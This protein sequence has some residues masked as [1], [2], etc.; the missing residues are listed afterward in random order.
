MSDHDHEPEPIPGLPEELP[1]GERILWQGAP[2]GGALAR[3]VF[4]VGIVTGYFAILMGWTAL[5]A[6]YDGRSLPVAAGEIVNLAV[7]AALALGLLAGLGYAYARSTMYTITNRRVAIRS[8]VALPKTVNV[9]FAQVKDA[10]VKLYNDGTGD[11]QT[12]L[13]GPERIN[14]LLLWPHVRPFKV[15]NAQPMLRSI[16]QP[17]EVARL[18]A[19][20]LTDFQAPAARAAGHGPARSG[21]TAGARETPENR[22]PLRRTPVATP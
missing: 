18:L 22:R 1:E 15:A 13:T 7:V 5:T 17:A 14:Y 20:A 12:T 6:F 2:R 3:R 21:N 9:P 8:G 11:L 16:E 10:Q 4:H 19:E